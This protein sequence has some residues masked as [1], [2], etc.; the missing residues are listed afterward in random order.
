MINATLCRTSLIH[1]VGSV[2]LCKLWISISCAWPPI[3]LHGDAFASHWLFDRVPFVVTD[4]V[5]HVCL[6]CCLSQWNMCA[7]HVR[8][9]L[10]SIFV[11]DCQQ[12]GEW[13]G[14]DLLQWQPRVRGIRTQAPR[15]V[16]RA[17]TQLKCFR[18]RSILAT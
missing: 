1:I 8:A 5:A 16:G 15:S 17:S 7:R 18:F 2:V 3:R 11:R 12:Q 9:H 4:A 13:K 6:G 10:E 14:S